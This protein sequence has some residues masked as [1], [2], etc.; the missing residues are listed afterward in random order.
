LRREADANFAAFL[1]QSP[2]G[3]ED[4]APVGMSLSDAG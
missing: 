2:F 4:V 1:A 3:P